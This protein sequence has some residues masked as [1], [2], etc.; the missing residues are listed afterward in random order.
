MSDGLRTKIDEVLSPLLAGRNSALVLGF[1]NHSNVGDSAIWLGEMAYLARKG[2]RVLATATNRA[3]DAKA[4]KRACPDGIVLCHG[5]GNFGDL[6]KRHQDLR[7]RVLQ[8]FAD[9]AVLLFPNT[10][11]FRDAR[12]LE[13]SKR[14]FEAHGNVTLLARDRESHDRMRAHFSVPVLLCPDLAH[15]AELGPREG[16][17]VQDLLYL[18][19]SDREARE[20]TLSIASTDWLSL[21]RTLVEETFNVPLKLAQWADRMGADQYQRRMVSLLSHRARLAVGRGRR[22]LSRGKVLIS[23]R[24]H[25]GLL[26]DAL[27]IPHVAL[28]NSYGKVHGYYGTWGLPP[29]CQLARSPQEALSLA[30]KLLAG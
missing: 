14:A 12:Y 21:P 27:R 18:R 26:A 22:L 29:G 19:R 24:L 16:E 13:R 17:P 4:L 20:E 25:A 6:W 23:D 15:W 2:I 28:D 10:F 9:R 1:P 7:L 11:F 8:D 3:Y 30:R 5:G